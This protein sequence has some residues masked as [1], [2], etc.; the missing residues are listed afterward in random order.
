M[1]NLSAEPFRLIEPPF[2]TSFEELPPSQTWQAAK[3]RLIDVAMISVAR[4]PDVS[5][6][7]E[8]AGDFGVACKGAVRSVLLFSQLAP[9]EMARQGLAVHLTAQSE[10]S[11]VLL[12]ELWR[13]E[14]GTPLVAAPSLSEA[15]GCLCIGNEAR[16]QLLSGEWPVTVDLCQWWHAQTGLPFVFAHWMIDASLSQRQKDEVRAWLSESVALAGTPE[17]MQRM[18]RRTLRQRLF[19]DQAA[20][21]TYFS[22]LISRFSQAEL[23]A[24]SYFLASIADAHATSNAI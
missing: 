6:V 22:A 11:V 2:A 3:N 7:M 18:I 21:Q 15:A 14:F 16:T 12:R 4:R 5:G 9:R 13:H 19:D 23:Q 10:T 24:E 20:A 1:N 17:G 8:S